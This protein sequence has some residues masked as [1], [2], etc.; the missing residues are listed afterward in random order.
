MN[1]NI[2][3][4]IVTFNPDI[5]ILNTVV[6]RLREQVSIVMLVDNNSDNISSVLEIASGYGTRVIRND[7]N[8]GLPGGLN[9]GVSELTS[10]ESLKWILVLDQDSIPDQNYVSNLISAFEDLDQDNVWA[11]RGV[12]KYAG[13]AHRRDEKWKMKYIRGSIMSGSLIKTEA[14]KAIS[15][16]EDFFMDFVDT[17]FYFEL[18]KRGHS[19]VSFNG[20][21]LNHALGGTIDLK[22]RKTTYHKSSRL[23]YIARNGM[24]LILEGKFD[25]KLPWIL[26][27][28]LLPTMYVEGVK[29]TL[30]HY[31]KGI[32]D[33]FIFRINEN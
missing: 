25:R 7:K 11:I 16:R 21:F 14:L 28:S 33:G 29:K 8:F 19:I 12:E 24:I 26:F 18:R 10:D 27:V 22:G 31:L 30:Y 1:A 5:K 9:E 13:K 15:F 3:G 23:Y 2:A 20:I 6:K 17:D 4:L 32:K